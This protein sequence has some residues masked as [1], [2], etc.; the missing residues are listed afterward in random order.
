MTMLETAPPP[1]LRGAGQRMALAF[2]AKGL[3]I[4]VQI[5]QQFFLVPLFLHYWGP[6]LY[7]DWLALFSTAAFLVLLDGGLLFYFSNSLLLSWSVGDRDRFHRTLRVGLSVYLMMVMAALPLAL[8][9]AWLMPWGSVL[10]LAAPG[11]SA[12][13]VMALLAVYLITSI[14]IAMILNVYRARGDHAVGICVAAAN[15]GAIL[16]ITA[17]GLALGI[18]PVQ[19]A[20]MHLVVSSGAWLLITMHQ[21]RRYRDIRYGLTLPN[22]AELREIVT[23]A[24]FYALVPAAMSLTLHGSIMLLAALGPGGGAVVV[25]A[26]L[27]TLTGVG[28]SITENLSQ[29]TGTELA[30]RF[31][32]GDDAALERLYKFTSRLFGALNGAIASL[33]AV[34]GPSFLS[35]WTL[36]KAPIDLTVFWSFLA[37]HM[38]ASPARA[39]E[40]VLLQINRPRKLA[41][42][43]LCRGIGAISLCAALIPAFGAAGAA[44]AVV[45]A[46]LAALGAIVPWILARETGLAP[47]RPVTL[48]YLATIGMFAIGF[49]AAEAAEAIIGG[50]SLM[51]LFAVAMLWAAVIAIPAYFVMFGAEHRRKIRARFRF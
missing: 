17:T 10:K 39:A 32:Q 9:A 35:I 13:D 37:L 7:R 30:R 22:R 38:L 8:A 46:E 24:P 28:R 26:T 42:A 45:V 12:A 1:D 51:Q 23:T 49:A 20:G 36:G 31:A 5:G 50:Q 18:G 44:A 41:L 43:H 33:I 25:F 29:V 47:L 6:E 11:V 4:V 21:R 14:P 27:R 48:S 2:L 16:V 3:V 40:G 15:G 19:L 34:I